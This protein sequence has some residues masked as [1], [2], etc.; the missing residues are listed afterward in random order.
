MQNDGCESRLR[1]PAAF[2]KKK[3]VRSSADSMEL[4]PNQPKKKAP[5][6]TGPLYI[7]CGV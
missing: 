5:D 7:F 2:E 3:L 4:V 1:K 6:I